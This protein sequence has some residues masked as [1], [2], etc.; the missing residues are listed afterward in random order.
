MKMTETVH[1]NNSLAANQKDSNSIAGSRKKVPVP[2]LPA[3][4]HFSNMLS[5]L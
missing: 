5:I 1:L 3:R 4:L 2:V